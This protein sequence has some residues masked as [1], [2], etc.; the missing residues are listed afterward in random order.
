MIHESKNKLFVDFWFWIPEKWKIF[1][2]YSKLVPNK[3]ENRLKV[4]KSSFIFWVEKHLT[5]QSLVFISCISVNNSPI[6]N[7]KAFLNN[8]R[9]K[10]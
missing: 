9:F 10:K 8:D 2:L 6:N 3:G 7:K 1:P 5:L 4:S